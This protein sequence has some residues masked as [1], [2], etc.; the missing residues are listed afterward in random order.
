MGSNENKGVSGRN[1]IRYAVTDEGR[2]W[3]VQIAPATDVR[4][5]RPRRRF[6]LL[7]G[8]QLLEILGTAEFTEE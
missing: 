5:P 3:D 8:F 1:E 4:E 6:A 7:P 2:N